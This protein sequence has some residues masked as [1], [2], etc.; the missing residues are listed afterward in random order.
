MKEG[1]IM[2]ITATE[3][4]LNLSKYLLLAESLIFLIF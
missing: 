1:F 3:S 2:Y 4:K